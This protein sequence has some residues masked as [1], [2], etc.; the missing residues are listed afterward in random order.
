MS[1]T[2]KTNLH[3]LGGE[4][5]QEKKSPDKPPPPLTCVECGGTSNDM[6]E[7]QVSP[8]GGTALADRSGWVPPI[9]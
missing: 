8:Q 7:E 1:T 2:K 4:K 5:K 9:C 3:N 6:I